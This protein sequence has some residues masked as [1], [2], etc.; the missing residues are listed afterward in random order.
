MQ[1]AMEE[2]INE[3]L[4]KWMQAIELM[5]RNIIA[6]MG[7]FNPGH[8]SLQVKH[9]ENVGKITGLRSYHINGEEV[10]KAWIKSGDDHT[11]TFTVEPSEKYKDA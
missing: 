4:N 2:Q 7:I 11:I 8:A 3:A 10:M 1:K 6:K 9:H 5:L